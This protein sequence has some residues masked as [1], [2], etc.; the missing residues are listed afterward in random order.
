LLFP[1]LVGCRQGKWRGLVE[2]FGAD[3]AGSDTSR[4]LLLRLSSF[5]CSLLG[6]FALPLLSFS[7]AQLLL[8]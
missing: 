5:G 2:G 3:K 8:F 1:V 7:S 6:F 4:F